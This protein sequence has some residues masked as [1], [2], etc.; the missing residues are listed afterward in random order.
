VELFRQVAG[1][2]GGGL[3][4]QTHVRILGWLQIVLGVLD[5]L[6]G[7]AAFGVMTGIGAISGD[8]EALGILSIIGGFAGAFML[9]MALPNLLVGIGLLRNWGSWVMIVAVIIGVINLLH[10]PIG[11][12]IAFYTFWVAWKLH[13]E[14]NNPRAITD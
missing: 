4:V 11:T 6:M 14:R 13:Q 2:D 3:E 1:P 10:F 7:M 5:V 12:A 8:A 9:F